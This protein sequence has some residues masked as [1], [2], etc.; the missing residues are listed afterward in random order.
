MQVLDEFNQELFIQEP[1]SSTV[2]SLLLNFG[3][4][5]LAQRTRLPLKTIYLSHT[6]NGSLS[7]SSSY[8]SSNL[9][10]YLFDTLPNLNFPFSLFLP[11]LDLILHANN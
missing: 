11:S 2:K 8:K 7:L 5:S 6:H 3:Y 1:I 9:S 4:N 10:R